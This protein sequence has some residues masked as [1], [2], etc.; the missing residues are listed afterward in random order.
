[1]VKNK[2]AQKSDWDKCGPMPKEHVVLSFQYEYSSE[3]YEKIQ[4]GVIPEQMEDKWFLYFEDNKLHCYRSWTGNCL[5]IVEFKVS[6]ESSQIV[7]LTVN[8]DREQ[9]TERDDNWD[10]HFVVYLINLLLLKKPTPFP[11]KEDVDPDTSA[12]QQWSLVGRAMFEEGE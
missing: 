2:K 5:Y 7:K 11:Q 8:R 12:V 10:C 1:M 4:Y 9:Y 3:D 6:E